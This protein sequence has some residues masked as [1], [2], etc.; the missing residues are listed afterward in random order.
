VRLE[1]VRKQYAAASGAFRLAGSEPAIRIVE[2]RAD[3]PAAAFYQD[4]LK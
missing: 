2:R 3:D 4:F 1:E